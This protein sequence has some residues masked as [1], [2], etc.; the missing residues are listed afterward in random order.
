MSDI[1]VFGVIVLVWVK[2]ALW[3][4]EGSV[5]GGLDRYYIL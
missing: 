1:I 3:R 4:G 2:I 5:G